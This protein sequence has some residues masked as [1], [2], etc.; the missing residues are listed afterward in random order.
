M[1]IVVLG[2]FLIGG[3]VVTFS[4]QL[5]LSVQRCLTIF[6]IK[7]NA[8]ARLNAEASTDWRLEIWSYLIPQ[9]PQYL[10][11]GKGLTFDANDMAMN[12]SLGNNQIGGDV[13]GQLTLAS[14]YHNGPLSVIIP[15]GIWGAIA[16]LWFLGAGIQV[17]WRNHKYG[18]PDIK[19]INTLLLCYFI[20]K[21]LLFMIVFGGFY[22][23]LV[24]FVGLVGFSISLNGGV[25]KR[26][27]A[28]V[29]PQV[30][31]NRFRPLPAAS[32]ATSS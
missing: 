19:K 25:A 16:F 23:E 30:V 1:P 26:A 21:T 17:L 5:P 3:L 9:V 11:L 28:E 10:L 27:L 14:D 20:A 18:D 24:T 22:S 2:M 12:Y 4:E 15:F 8:E 29:H 7:I 31:F 32:P 13:G 6:P